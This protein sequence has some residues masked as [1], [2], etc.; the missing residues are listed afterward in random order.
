VIYVYGDDG[1][2]EKK[3]RATAVS[4]IAGYEEWWADLEEKWLA[5][6]GGIPFHATECESD[7]GDYAGVPH[8]Q[9]KA[10]YR[11]LTTLLV[12]S[13]VGGIAIAID[14]VA[15]R[16]VFPYSPDLA[17]YKA[18]TECLSRVGELG[19]NLREVA[20]LT[21]D[22]SKENEYNASLLYKHA[23]DAEQ[24][25]LVWLHP[26]ISFVPWRD[27]PRVQAADLLTYEAWKALD[28]T[29]GPVKR[30][31]ASWEAL[32]A[33]LRFETFSYGEEWFTDLRGHIESGDLEKRVEFNQGDYEE[34][35]RDTNRH[36]DISNLF[37]FVDWITKK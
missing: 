8:E 25:L 33:T 15:Q 30:K 9:N 28:H 20:K 37:H 17:Y 7:H 26:E 2:D 29:V 22:I 14:L 18:F 35:L 19:K 23:R 34:W 5:R 10:M 32:R 36:H 21:F 11:D 16:N 24:E 1:A 4:V 12:N 13:K 3:E 27:S 31:R 6:C